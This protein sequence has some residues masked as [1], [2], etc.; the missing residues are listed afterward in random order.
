MSDP[1]GIQFV[2]SSPEAVAL[3][4]F[5]IIDAVEANKTRQQIFDLYSECLRVVQSRPPPKE[6]MLRNLANALPLPLPQFDE[7]GFPGHGP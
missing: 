1:P 7:P 2:E 4:L 6:K 3:K 5:L